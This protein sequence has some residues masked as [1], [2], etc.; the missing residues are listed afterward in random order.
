MSR[1][2]YSIDYDTLNL[3]IYQV[4]SPKEN[5]HQLLDQVALEFLIQEEGTNNAKIYKTKDIPTD[6]INEGYFLHC[7]PGSNIINL[8]NKKR[9]EVKGYFVNSL[10]TKINKIRFY[11]IKDIKKFTCS[12]QN[13]NLS[14]IPSTSLT[15]DDEKLNDYDM[16]LDELKQS[17]HFKRRLEIT[18]IPRAPTPP[19]RNYYSQ[20][21]TTPHIYGPFYPYSSQL[22]PFDDDHDNKLLSSDSELDN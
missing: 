8:Y 4:T 22:P 21:S 1:A 9:I 16:L 17:D 18:N 20:I 12:D 3:E 5:A 7:P 13:K 19:P 14:E 10:D 11:G 2:I 15:K 6:Q